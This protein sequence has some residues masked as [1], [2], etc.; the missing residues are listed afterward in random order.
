MENALSYQDANTRARVDG[1]TGLPNAT[2]LFLH[3]ESEMARCSRA[4]STLTVLV[5]DL[6]GFK[7]IN[8]RQGHLVGNQVLKRVAEAFR[9]CCREYD[10]V[11]RMGGDEFVF[12]LPGIPAEALPAKIEQVDEAVRAAARGI[13][14]NLS[15]SLGC[16]VYPDDGTEAETLLAEADRRMYGVKR[17]RK[18]NLVPPDASRSLLSLGARVGN[19]GP[20][21]ITAP[22]VD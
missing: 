16:A 8:D 22:V 19:G 21:T 3:L 1:L 6:D 2:A 9:S 10:Y 14:P 18:E 5:S 20:P 11:G 17:R 4:G 7:Q 12:V 13:D 15:V